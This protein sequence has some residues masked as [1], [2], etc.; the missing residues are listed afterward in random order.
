[1]IDPSTTIGMTEKQIKIGQMSTYCQE[2]RMNQ[3]VKRQ[4]S[5][6]KMI[7]RR[8]NLAKTGGTLVPTTMK[9]NSTKQSAIMV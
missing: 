8:L 3:S 9:M 4:P 7:C 5:R 6:C 1:M 2:S